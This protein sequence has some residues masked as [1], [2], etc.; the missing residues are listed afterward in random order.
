[1]PYFE[2]DEFPCMYSGN[3]KSSLTF[4]NYYFYMLFRNSDQTKPL[5]MYLNGG[6]GSTSMN[7]VFMENGPLKAEWTG[8]DKYSDEYKVIYD[9]EDSWMNIGSLLFI[10]QPVGTGWSWGE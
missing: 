9:H 2:G 8:T 3:L 1:M 7:A 5:I 6:P 4:D 10:D